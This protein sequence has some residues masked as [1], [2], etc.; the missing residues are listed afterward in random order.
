MC[1][2]GTTTN[3]APYASDASIS[4]TQGS[5]KWKGWKIGNT[6]GTTY[7]SV[8]AQC[9]AG[10]PEADT[11]Y[12]EETTIPADINGD[13]TYYKICTSQP[14]GNDSVTTSHY[15]NTGVPKPYKGYANLTLYANYTTNTFGVTIQNPDDYT[16]KTNYT[17][18]L[19]GSGKSRFGNNN[20]KY[21]DLNQVVLKIQKLIPF[22]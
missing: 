19:T 22:F 2:D 12:Y 11:I 16:F 5:I 17:I 13:T 9:S 10:D 14:Y 15:K 21:A 7:P 3:A 6:S 20:Y 1:P 18:G 8:F 4:L